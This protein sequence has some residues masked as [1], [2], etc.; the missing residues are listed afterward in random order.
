[1][2]VNRLRIRVENEEGISVHSDSDDKEHNVINPEQSDNNAIKK[3]TTVQSKYIASSNQQPDEIR[4]GN[5][6]RELLEQNAQ[7]DNTSLCSNITE[8]V[9][10]LDNDIHL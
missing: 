8:M 2:R 7:A 4:P 3:S 9:G 1:M 10:Q 5:S 6:V